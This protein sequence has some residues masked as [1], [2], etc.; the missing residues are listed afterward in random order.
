MLVCVCVLLSQPSHCR[1]LLYVKC[2]CVLS[3]YLSP[4]IVEICYML[5]AC[6]CVVLLSQPSIV[7]ICY[8]LNVCVCVSCYLSPVIVE[9]CYILNVCVCCPVISAQYCRDLLYIKC[10]CVCVVLLSQPSHCRDLVIC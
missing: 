9:I 1:D 6:V 5:N 7:E 3:C 2:L 8:I 4:V 10:L